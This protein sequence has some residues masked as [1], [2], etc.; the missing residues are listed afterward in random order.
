MRCERVGAGVMLFP[1]EVALGSANVSQRPSPGG[2]P[3]QMHFR[4]FAIRKAA[5]G[6]AGGWGWGRGRISSLQMFGL[7]T[8]DYCTPPHPSE[9]LSHAN[10][11]A[12]VGQ[13]WRT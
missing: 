2:P 10:P 8:G 13:N 11:A 12:C 9:T 3:Q 4:I 6:W 7:R 5:R 1:V